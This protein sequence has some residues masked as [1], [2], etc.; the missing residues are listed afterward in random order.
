VAIYSFRL[1]YWHLSGGHVCA[2]THD[3]ILEW[4]TKEGMYILMRMSLMFTVRKAVTVYLPVDL[5]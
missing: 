5:F 1:K 4:F 2:G 3:I